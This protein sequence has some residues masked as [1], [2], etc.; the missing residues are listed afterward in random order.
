LKLDHGSEAF[1][2]SN[3]DG[4]VSRFDWKTGIGKFLTGKGHGKAVKALTSSGDSLITVGLDDRL[5]V[6]DKKSNKWSTDA[7]AL[8]G[9]PVHV[10][11]GKKDSTLV[12][13]ALANS[14][15][16]L[17]H[18]GT[19][20]GT[21]SIGFVPNY[22]DFSADDSE[23]VVGGKDKKVHFFSV[24][25]DGFKHTKEYKESDK[26]VIIA[27]YRP[28]QS[29][30]ATVDRDKRIYFFNKDGK[31]LNS[32]GWEYHAATVSA[33]AWSPSGKRYATG[34]ADESIIVWSDLTKFSEDSRL[35]IKDAHCTG[36]DFVA[37]WDEDTLVSVGS[38]R[39][40]RIWDLPKSS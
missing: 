6:N 11:S 22:V 27:H 7:I 21:T 40:I 4:Q 39:S 8:G 32:L 16:V 1:Y 23:L 10:T 20:K 3:L 37:F 14:N 9:Q 24:T 35:L 33:G 12:A 28:D 26:E 19:I 17:L 25:G 2:V 29:L 18:K 34:S 31:N 36:V 5:R 38:D 15:L 13:V 30:V